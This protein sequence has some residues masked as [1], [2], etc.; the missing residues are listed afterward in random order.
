M[1]ANVSIKGTKAGLVVTLAEEPPLET[2]VSELAARLKQGEA[3]FRDARITLSVGTRALTAD[4]WESLRD[5]LVANGV[6]LQ[7]VIAG[8]QIGQQAA[9]AAGLA[10]TSPDA[11]AQAAR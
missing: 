8:A 6:T 2:V 4:E 7:N 3:F 11:G 1:K 10:V 9:R 5:L